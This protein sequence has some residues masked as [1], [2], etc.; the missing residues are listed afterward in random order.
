M[1]QVRMVV[2]YLS[3]DELWFHAE[4]GWYFG[5]QDEEGNMLD[6]VGPYASADEA[7][8][9]LPPDTETVTIYLNYGVNENGSAD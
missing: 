4:A 9:D 2:R 3:G 6:T 8:A 1:A 5:L 7:V